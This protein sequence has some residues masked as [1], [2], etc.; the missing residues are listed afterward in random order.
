MYSQTVPTDTTQNLIPLTNPDNGDIIEGIYV[1]HEE[2]DSPYML[3][4]WGA[5]IT[6]HQRVYLMGFIETMYA[7]GSNSVYADTDSIKCEI[8]IIMSVVHDGTVPI[9]NEYGQF[10]VEDICQSFTVIGGKCYYG[11]TAEGKV[12]L[13]AKGIPNNRLK[14]LAERVFLQA[15][16]DLN[17]PMIVG[18]KAKRQETLEKGIEFVGVK[19]V[20]SIIKE[21]SYVRPEIH[22]RKITD[23]RNSWAWHVDED[24][25]IRPRVYTLEGEQLRA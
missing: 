13:K 18:T 15:V 10:K 16:K 19:S 7:R 14:P 3:P 6:A 12:V 24:L 2:T 22:R 25:N 8:N 1:G 4:H 11:T 23:I 9:G 5:L 21:N 17:S 20:I